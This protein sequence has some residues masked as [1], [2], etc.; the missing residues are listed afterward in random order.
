MIYKSRKDNFFRIILGGIGTCLV[1]F[2]VYLYFAEGFTNELLVTGIIFT[3][4][5]VFLFSLWTNTFFQI[6]DNRLVYSASFIKGK[7]EIKNI[8]KITT[9][10]TKFIGLKLGLARNGIC[11]ESSSHPDIYMTPEHEEKFISEILKINSS[12]KMIN[13]KAK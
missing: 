1:G 2:F 8:T 3:I 12:I 7:V 5:I 10:V 11:I 6:K 13:Q 9:Q 4:I